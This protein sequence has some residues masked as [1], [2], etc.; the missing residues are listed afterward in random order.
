MHDSAPHILAVLCEVAYHDRGIGTG[1]AT[2]WSPRS[3]DFNP[4]D[5]YLWGHLKSLVYAVP[6]DNEEALHHRIMN[7]C[8]ASLYGCGGP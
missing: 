6:V 3:P 1:G 8:K 2:A 7:A 4:L 5:F